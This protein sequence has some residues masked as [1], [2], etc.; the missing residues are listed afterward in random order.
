M[1]RIL[2]KTALAAVVTAVLG[3]AAQAGQVNISVSVNDRHAQKVVRHYGDHQVERRNV[4]SPWDHGHRYRP[5]HGFYSRPVLSE[6]YWD[7]PRWAGAAYG[8]PGGYHDDCRSIVKKTVSP[9][10]TTVKHIKICE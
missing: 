10:R 3:G 7:R 8:R 4:G 9:W 2:T 5:E 6:G 1:I